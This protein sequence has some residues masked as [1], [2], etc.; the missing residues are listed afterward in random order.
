MS[1]VRQTRV[2]NRLISRKRRKQSERIARH[3]FKNPGEGSTLATDVGEEFFHSFDRVAVA[4]VLA[5]CK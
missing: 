5:T 2:N 4:T 1:D 3:F